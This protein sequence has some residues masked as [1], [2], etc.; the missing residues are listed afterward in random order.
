[1]LR[2]SGVKILKIPK[3][4]HSFPH[5]ATLMPMSTYLCVTNFGIY[6]NCHEN[7]GDTYN[8]VPKDH[9]LLSNPLAIRYLTD[10]RAP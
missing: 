2:R 7:P 9:N 3:V 1:M 8:Y 4:L 10:C 5:P 6:P